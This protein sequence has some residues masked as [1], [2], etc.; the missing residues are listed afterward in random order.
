MSRVGDAGGAGSEGASAL[1]TELLPA[2]LAD[3]L[4]GVLVTVP[5]VARRR[6]AAAAIATL[7]TLADGETIQVCQPAIPLCRLFLAIGRV[8]ALR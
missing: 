2:E 5:P 4:M 1:G 6:L 8:V 3:I 7:A